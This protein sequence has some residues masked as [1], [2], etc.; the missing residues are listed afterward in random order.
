MTRPTERIE[1]I[2]TAI[3]NLWTLY[4]NLRLG[5]LLEN[6]V[7]MYYGSIAR[8]LFYTEDSDLLASLIQFTENYIHVE[9]EGKINDD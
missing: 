2:L 9:S 3:R 4:P 6:V 8:D 5:Q 7:D 1:P